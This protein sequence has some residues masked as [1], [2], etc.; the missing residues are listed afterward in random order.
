MGK[1]ICVAVLLAVL[2]GAQTGGG[3]PEGEA[4]IIPKAQQ[5]GTA[6]WPGDAL[7]TFQWHSSISPN[8]LLQIIMAEGTD[9]IPATIIIWPDEFPAEQESL[10]IIIHRGDQVVRLPLRLHEK[11]D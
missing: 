11:E 4:C 5:D 8:P 1:I 3:C 6:L 9:H 7:Q 2:A 10:E